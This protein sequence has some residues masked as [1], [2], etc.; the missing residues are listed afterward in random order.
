MSVRPD[1]GKATVPEPGTNERPQVL[2]PYPI[3]WWR[4]VCYVLALCVPTA[5]FAFGL[6]YWNGPD[7][8]SRRFSRWCLVLGLA[9]WVFGSLGQAFWSGF[10]GGEAGIRPW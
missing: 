3:G 2:L 10:E 4:A 1:N 9:G 6:L 5:G 8:R 7:R